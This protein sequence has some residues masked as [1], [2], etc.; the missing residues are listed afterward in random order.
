MI[1]GF[2]HRGLKRLFEHG[3]RRGMNPQHVVKIERILAVLDVAQSIDEVNLQSFRL[4]ALSGDL[5]GFWAVTV[6]ANWRVIFRFED[7]TA[8]DVDL[9]DYH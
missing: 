2:R 1:A 6:S 7:G 4:H 3:D 8:W 5:K 9:V